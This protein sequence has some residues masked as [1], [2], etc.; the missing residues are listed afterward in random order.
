MAA[1]I[2][3]VWAL[4]ASEFELATAAA[5]CCPTVA[6]KASSCCSSFLTS[7]ENGTTPRSKWG[8][9]ATGTNCCLKI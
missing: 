2:E 9:P 7:A 6:M 1:M 3:I 5:D 8:V 4:D